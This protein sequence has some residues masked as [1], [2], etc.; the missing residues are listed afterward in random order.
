[1]SAFFCF[2]GVGCNYYSI[3]AIDWGQQLCSQANSTVPS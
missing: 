2:V 3:H 1:M